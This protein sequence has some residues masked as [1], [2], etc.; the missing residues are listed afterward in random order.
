MG[1]S[2]KSVLALCPL[3][4]NPGAMLLVE[5]EEASVQIATF[6]FKDTHNHFA[7]CIL[8]LLDAQAVDLC[9]GVGA[10]DDYTGDA[11]SDDEV[12]T[13]RRL[14][15]VGA[16]LKADVY[17]ASAEQT[18]VL[19]ASDGIHLGMRT[20]AATMESLAD[21]ASVAHHDGSHHRIRRSSC[22]SAS[23]KLKASA[24]EFYVICGI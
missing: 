21:D 7:S 22:L 24:H 3:E 12:G 17:C 15:E 16:R 11:A 8:Q 9:E 2:Y 4:Q 23:C 20:A 5:R 19:D 14:A 10:S 1:L 13:W 18:L 6:F